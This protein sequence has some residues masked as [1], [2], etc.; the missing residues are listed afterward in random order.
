MSDDIYQDLILD[1]FK[2]PRNFGEIRD[3][4]HFGRAFNTVCGD[5]VEVFL[6]IRDGALEEIA[7]TPVGCAI[8]KASASMMTEAVKGLKVPDAESVL[9]DVWQLID[10]VGEI[11]QVEGELMALGQLREY[12]MRQQCGLLPWKALKEALWPDKCTIT[13]AP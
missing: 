11:P 8:C 7:A 9:K 13:P 1:H 2:N 6:V 4:T 10:G 3:K 12:P 5:S